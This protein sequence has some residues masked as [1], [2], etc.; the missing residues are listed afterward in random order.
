VT[1]AAR[2]SELRVG[3]IG[4]GGAGIAHHLY[5]SMVS[6]CRTTRVFD[7]K[8][9]G[10]E[11]AR[12]LAPECQTFDRLD[13]FLDGLDIVSVCTPDDTHAA[14]VAAA[15]DRG[16]HVL[17]EK[18]LASSIEDI[19]VIKDAQARSSASVAVLHQ[20]RF[21]PLFERMREALDG[22]EIG[23]LSYLEG[24]YVHDL[25][26]RAF[27]YDDWRATS[28]ATPLVYAGCHFV[29]LLRW[30]TH[31]EPA[32]VHATAGH[33][34]FPGYPESDLNAAVYRFGSGIVGKVLV[35]IG[36][37]GPQDHSVRVYGST[38][39][40]DNAALF[41]RNH[42]WRRTLHMPALVHSALLRQMPWPRRLRATLGQIRRHAVPCVTAWLFEGL[43]RLA[44]RD[45][46]YAL[47]H[48]PVRLYE[49]RLACL[50]AVENFVASVR[51][52]AT[53]R[54]DVD[55]SARTVL[56]C[57]AGVESYR[58][59]RTVTVEPLDRVL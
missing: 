50:R 58:S 59:G 42:R 34:V 16:V 6:G 3:V 13:S 51:G 45:N 41:D 14:Y 43:R 55:D 8:T 20:M 38:G 11:R 49:H 1:R 35:A 4:F 7:V 46:E 15:L 24:Y 40:I 22:G 54:C 25:T 57:L 18:P 39:M 29:D 28:N 47:R 10:L 12:R 32:E 48:F 33:R 52:T 36:T 5:Y 30:F 26:E 21:V 37:P 9:G 53:A 44:P 17:V 56:A 31:E 23:V 19:R 27:V 2:S